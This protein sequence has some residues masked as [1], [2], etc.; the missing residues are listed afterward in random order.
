MKKPRPEVYWYS[1]KKPKITALDRDLVA[2]IVIVGGGIA[3]LM[4]AQRIRRENKNLS[5]VVLE[6]TICGGGAS[7]KSSGFITPDS[8]L[9]L[10][11]L[12]REYGDEK[13]KQLWDFA[14]KGVA[15]IRETIERRNLQCD[16]IVQDS[17][18][19]A[20]NEKGYKEVVDEFNTQKKLG[21]NA[22]LFDSKNIN[23]ILG[24]RHYEGGVR[25]NE[26]FGMIS[27]LFCQELKESLQRDSIGGTMNI[28]EETPV[29]EV[30]PV[31][32]RTEKYIIQAEKIVVCTDHFLPK[33]NLVKDEVYH[34]QTFLALSAPLP[35][36]VITKMFPDKPLMVWDTDL[37]YQYYRIVEGNR[38]LLGGSNILY[39][40]ARK[41]SGQSTLVLRKMYAYLAKKFPSVKVEFEY[42]WSGLIGVSKDF[43]PIAGRDPHHKN[44]FFVGAGAGLPWAAGLG[45]YIA[46]KILSG[47]DEFD[48]AFS[49]LRK[50]PI[51][52]AAQVILSKPLSFAISHGIKK[53]FK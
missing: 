23:S 33:F 5:V 38:L 19:V 37:I 46:D 15:S 31:G 7:G 35:Q 1:L 44:M 32:V 39:T 13:A 47:R 34:A 27:Y 2:D 24:S 14:K 25:T 11:D 8:E 29:V 28:Y 40:Y 43:L 30:T 53:Y 12:V 42:M 17:L 18:F 6:A 9:E 49:P 26:T 16:Y 22:S 41:P 45:E 21:Y 52:H 10:S 50:F 36:E 48:E 51:G 4:C 3:G 20:N